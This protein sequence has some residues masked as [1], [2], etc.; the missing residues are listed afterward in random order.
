MERTKENYKGTEEWYRTEQREKDEKKMRR[1]EE[2]W[3]LKRIIRFLIFVERIS[4]TLFVFTTKACKAVTVL[5]QSSS[6][7]SQQLRS[8][9]QPCGLLIGFSIELHCTTLGTRRDNVQSR[10][11]P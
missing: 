5:K 1:E 9:L 3:A 11:L 8:F 4:I 7:A 2:K 6:G 10:L